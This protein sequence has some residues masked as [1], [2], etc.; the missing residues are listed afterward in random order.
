MAFWG[1][2]GHYELISGGHRMPL[3]PSSLVLPASCCQEVCTSALTQVPWYHILPLH[4]GQKQ[5]KRA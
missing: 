5:H 3:D 2:V 4:T 1:E